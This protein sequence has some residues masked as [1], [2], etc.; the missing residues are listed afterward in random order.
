MDRNRG[1]L[2]LSFMQPLARS[3][4]FVRLPRLQPFLTALSGVARTQIDVHKPWS[5]SRIVPRR[6]VM[7]VTVGYRASTPL[8]LA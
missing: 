6:A 8:K 5:L 3:P 4:F 1:S 2:L 7:Y